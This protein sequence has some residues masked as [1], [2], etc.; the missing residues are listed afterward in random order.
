MNSD[1]IY[2][3]VGLFIV[4]IF[5]IYIVL[6]TLNFQVKIIEGMATGTSTTDTPNDKDKIADA[7]ASN[8][9]FA[10]DS[11]LI[12]KYQKSYEDII[13]NLENNINY[14]I[15]GAIINSGE[16][17][18]KKP[19]DPTSIGLINS[20]NSLK[21]FKDTLNDSMTFLDKT[22]GNT[23]SDSS[24]SSSSDKSSNMFSF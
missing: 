18:S 7:I 15:L 16:L 14:F 21:A 11:L 6:R 8:T 2:K 22:G 4:S 19:M 12:S 17:I 20:I 5:V 24:S 10:E 13:I 3:Y 23:N 1:S 9:T